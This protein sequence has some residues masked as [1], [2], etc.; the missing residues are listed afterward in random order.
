MTEQ[1][2]FN[3]ARVHD[4]ED[5]LA[6]SHKYADA[7]WWFEIYRKAFPTMRACVDVRKDGWAQRGGIDRVL[8][9]ECGRTIKIDEKVRQQAWDDILLERWSDEARKLAGW[10]QKPLACEFINYAFIPIRTCYL[11]PTLTLQRA[12]KLHGR[13]WCA[14]HKEIRAQNSKYVTVSVAVPISELFAA[15]ADAMK[16]QW[17]YDGGDDFEK[18]I[19]ACY[20][21]VRERKAN[22]GKGWPE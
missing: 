2:S 7:P 21:A 9:L 16:I 17:E 4:F 1:T 19:N 5:S 22:G 10:I 8:T 12:W 11:L 15:L 6:L 13:Q 3:F 20:D 14:R 18:S